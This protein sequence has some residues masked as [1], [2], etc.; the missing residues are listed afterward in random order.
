[1][2]STPGNVPRVIP[3]MQERVERG[4]GNQDYVAATAT[5]AAGW[6]TTRDKLLAPESR[7]TV[8]SVTPL[9][10]NLG[11]IY[12]HPKL[13]ATPGRAVTALRRRELAGNFF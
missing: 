10:V 6:T 8:T 3:Q 13:K 12:K 5:V 2:Q 9:N 1:M 4:V 11:P 7:N